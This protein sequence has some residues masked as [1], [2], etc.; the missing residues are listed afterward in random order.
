[1]LASIGTAQVIILQY[2]LWEKSDSLI[3]V[4][5]CERPL[6]P[7]IAAA[8]Q[9]PRS[10]VILYRLHDMV[11]ISAVEAR[12]PIAQ[13][14]IKLIFAQICEHGLIVPWSSPPGR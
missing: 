2:T 3:E 12:I 5:A 9:L 10:L 14:E 7:S 4:D 1:M 8:R 11:H 13:P 6:G